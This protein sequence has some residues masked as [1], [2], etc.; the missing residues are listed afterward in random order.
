[1][2]LTPMLDRRSA[3]CVLAMAGIYRRLL[4]RIDADPATALSGRMS[5]P[6][7]REGLGRRAR[8]AGGR[9]MRAGGGRSAAGSRASRRHS[10]APRPGAQRDAR[11]GQAPAR[12]RGL[13][14]RA[15]RSADGQRPA[16]VPALLR[17]LP[18]A[19]RAP[20]Q[21][22]SRRRPGAPGDPRAEPRPPARPH[23]PQ[24]AARAAAPR[25]RAAP[26]PAPATRR[27]TRRR[28]GRARAGAARPARPGPRKVHLR[29]V[30]LA[31]RPGRGV[32]RSAVGPDRAAHDERSCRRG[33]AC[34]GRIR[35]PHRSAVGHR[36]RRHRLPRRDAAGD[37]RRP[38]A[39]GARAGRRRVAPRLARRAPRARRA[40]A[41]PARRPQSGESEEIRA[42]AAVVALPH[43]RVGA[44]VEPLL[45]AN[46]GRPARRSR[47]R[48][49][50][51]CTSS[52]TAAC[53]T[54]RSPPAWARPCST[55]STAETRPARRPA[56]SISL[57]RCP[58][59]RRRWSSAW[60]SCASA[61]CR[62]CGSCCRGHARRT[63]SAS[64]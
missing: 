48:R 30:A 61:T 47:A 38:G 22:A 64:R 53:S 56:V 44:L 50:S 5:L 51:T 37:H 3:A 39:A 46:A 42:D 40:T 9:S 19:A 27:A 23:P 7:R 21:R 54:S 41:L 57:C 14:V 11:R 35:V 13:L 36:R 43:D 60:R 18:G 1:M 58:G 16:R 10:T 32:G 17:G 55:C 59:P 49:S 6:T 28:A 45:G 4:E 20:R 34:A 25:G 26:L 29:R 62:R 33:L 15:R 63:S 2:T 24:L 52:T 12:R 31:P 8:P